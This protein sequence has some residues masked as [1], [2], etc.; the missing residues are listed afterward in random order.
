LSLEYLAVKHHLKN[1][2]E[3][4]HRQGTVYEIGE[5]ATPN[6][7]VWEILLAEIGAG[8][9]SAA[10]ETERALTFFDPEV[11]L[12]VGIGGGVKDVSLGDVVV[13]TKVYGYE[14]GKANKEFQARPDLNVSSYPLQQRARAEARRDDWLGRLP[15]AEKPRVLVGPIASGEKVVASR[16]SP[17]YRFLKDNYGDALAVEMEGKG[18]LQV[19]HSNRGTQA[20]VVRGI[21]D[22][23]SKKSQSDARGWQS[24]AAN[25][26]SAFAFEVLA[27]YSPAIP[28]D[29]GMQPE[30]AQIVKPDMPPLQP[31]ASFAFEESPTLNSLL[32]PVKLGDWEASADAAL[33]VVME[34]MPDGQNPVFEALLRYYNNPTEDM[35]WG[36]LQTIEC[37]AG[38]SPDLIDR[39]MLSYL[40]VHSDFSNRASAASICMVLANY[41]PSRVPIDIAIRLSRHDEDW[42]VQAPANA[43]LKTLV[44]SMPNVQRVYFTRLRSSDRFEREH[45]ATALLGIARQE[46]ELIDRKA[47]KHELALLRSLGDKTS[48]RQI[49]T[50]LTQKELP[51]AL[52]SNTVSSQ[53][54]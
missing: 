48:E 39:G 21:S 29:G 23:L 25:H 17:L 51:D 38:L 20:L 18:F 32:E 31:V 42:Y 15:D 37:V 3:R 24:K 16:R 46:P 28:L 40:A 30:I 2:S 27:K 43:A 36:A 33:A 53:V 22:L 54:R 10:G 8:N 19:A 13:A 4:T 6:G 26:A 44:R 7:S 49:K 14:S 41:A 34:T 35:R 1:I 11:A 45:A 9:P 50:A 52:S 12:F 5:F 47:M